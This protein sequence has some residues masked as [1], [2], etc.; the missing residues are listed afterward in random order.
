MKVSGS[1]GVAG[2]NRARKSGAASGD[3]FAPASAPASGGASSAAGAAALAGTSSIGSVDALLALQGTGDFT[4]ARK[5][6]TNRA[7]SLLDILD[8]LKIALLEGQIP[9]D[10][11]MRLMDTLQSQRDMTHDPQLEAALDEVELRAA[12]ELAKLGN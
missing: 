3:G 2:P 12:V 10:T 9:R 1:N 8:D 7:F 4:E 5:Q 11:L 6:A